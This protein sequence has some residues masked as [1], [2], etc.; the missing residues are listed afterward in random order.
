[1]ARK[2]SS[3]RYK[4]L[5]VELRDKPDILAFMVRDIRKDI[6]CHK[7]LL[8]GLADDIVHT[9]A[10]YKKDGGADVLEVALEELKPRTKAY[11]EIKSDL[12]YW[13]GNYDT[14]R[15]YI[16]DGEKPPVVPRR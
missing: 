11:R 16:Y 1:M 5:K 8:E 4:S 13:K 12:D 2:K 3:A 14:I 10:V 9:G 15:K 6:E 7:M